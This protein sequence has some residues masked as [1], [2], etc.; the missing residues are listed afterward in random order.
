MN[1][2]YLKQRPTE[3]GEIIDV[4]LTAE[5]KKRLTVRF[6]HGTTV[7]ADINEFNVINGSES[8]NTVQ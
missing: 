3:I 1:Y 4:Y 8:N 7:D 6:G 5:G 2:A